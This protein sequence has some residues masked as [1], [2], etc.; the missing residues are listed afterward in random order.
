MSKIHLMA[1]RFTLRRWGWIMV[2]IIL[3]TDPVPSER[4]QAWFLLIASVVAAASNSAAP[5]GDL[6]LTKFFP[7]IHFTN[8][9]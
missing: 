5:A 2:P 3:T 4:S 6:D 8:F 1:V 9:Y 7:F